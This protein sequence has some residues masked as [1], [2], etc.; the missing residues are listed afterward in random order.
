MRS[1][2]AHIMKN[3]HFQDMYSSISPE[4]MA[5]TPAAIGLLAPKNPIARFRNLPG[6]Q[7]IPIIATAFG[8]IKA[9]PIP[10]IARATLKAM[11]LSQK[12]FIRDHRVSQAPPRRTMFRWPYTAPSLP[13]AS[14]KVPCVN[15]SQCL[16]SVQGEIFGSVR[17]L[18]VGRCCP[19]GLPRT[20][21]YT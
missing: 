6:G 13:L 3:I 11:K 15:L 8:M 14:T 16:E 5:P 17:D 12:P 21:V 2:V 19:V 20:G 7:A 4:K 10:D 9:P 18:L 1:P